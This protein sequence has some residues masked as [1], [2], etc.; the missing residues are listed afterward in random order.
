MNILLDSNVLIAAFTTRGLCKSVFEVCLSRYTIAISNHI[1]DEIMK[2][3]CNKFKMPE[4]NVNK[5]ISFLKEYCILI[6]SNKLEGNIC[7]DKEDEK[8]LSICNNIKINYLITGDKDLLVLEKYN[9]TP[10]ISPREFW[11]RIRNN[12]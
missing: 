5:I 9:N 8:V 10:I 2:I 11:E 7:R 4:L 6:K 1:L 3:L 12:E